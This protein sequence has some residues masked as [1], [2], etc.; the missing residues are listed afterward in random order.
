MGK[1]I[2]D[3]GCLKR[4]QKKKDTL[5]QEKEKEKEKRRRKKKMKKYYTTK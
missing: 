4:D 5:S 2:D 3:R 1:M